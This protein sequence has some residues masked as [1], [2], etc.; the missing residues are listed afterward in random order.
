MDAVRVWLY[1]RQNKE[2]VDAQLAVLKEAAASNGFSI[3]GMSCDI[4][5]SLDADRIGL[6]EAEQVMMDRQADVLLVERISVISRDS[7]VVLDILQKIEAWGGRVTAVAGGEPDLAALRILSSM[8][9]E[10]DPVCEA[11]GDL[12]D[13]RSDGCTA[14]KIVCDGVVYD[15]IKVS[16]ESDIFNELTQDQR[17]SGF[18]SNVGFFRHFD[19]RCSGFFSNVGFFRHFGC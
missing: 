12:V 16:G 19:Q 5:S 4:G 10:P 8:P 9:T 3:Q 13:H 7:H 18:F 2:A 1:A 6:Q 11:C 17:C 15:R 14:D